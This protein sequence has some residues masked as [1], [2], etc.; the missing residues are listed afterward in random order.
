MPSQLSMMV[1]TLRRLPLFADLS[2]PQLALIAEGVKT[3][4]HRAGEVIF[5]EG[6]PCR[7]LLIVKEGWVKLLKTAANGRRQLAA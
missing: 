6:D 3:Q 4:A 1:A 2:E 7:E 5:S